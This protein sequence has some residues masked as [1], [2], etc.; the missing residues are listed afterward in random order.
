MYDY[1]FDDGGI[2]N[3]GTDDDDEAGKRGEVCFLTFC[4]ILFL[5]LFSISEQNFSHHYQL[6][7]Q[8]LIF[9]YIAL[10]RSP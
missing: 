5:S 9:C 6:P 4:H 10:H 3:S 8:V 1:R 7:Q 2:S